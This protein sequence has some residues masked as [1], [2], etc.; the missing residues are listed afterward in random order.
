MDDSPP[1]SKVMK[2]QLAANGVDTTLCSCGLEALEIL[3]EGS[4]HFDI[5]FTDLH[6]PDSISGL[7]LCI[8]IKARFKIL[9]VA[10]SAAAHD[11]D[12]KEAI[13]HGF[14]DLL[15]KPVTKSKINKLL[16]DMHLINHQTEVVASKEET[17]SLMDDGFS[18]INNELKSLIDDIELH[19]ER[20]DIAGLMEC[21]HQILEKPFAGL[22]GGVSSQIKTIQSSLRE[23]EVPTGHIYSLISTLSQLSEMEV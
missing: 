11:S 18:N 21:C 12:Y 5:V 15:L 14:S 22:L 3:H 2:M 20:H 13:E 6:M 23:D 8:E 4:E 1:A 16:S 7:E 17:Y 9:V 10:V 19:H